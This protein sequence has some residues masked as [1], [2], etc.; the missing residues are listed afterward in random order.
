[1]FVAS[2][3]LTTLKCSLTVFDFLNCLRATTHF[4]RRRTLLYVHLMFT[5]MLTPMSLVI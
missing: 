1:M 3:E 2:H 4:Q 5:D